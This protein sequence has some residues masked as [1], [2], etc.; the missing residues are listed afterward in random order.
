MVLFWKHVCE[1]V[2]LFKG[3]SD[4][5]KAQNSRTQKHDHQKGKK[6]MSYFLHTNFSF[7]KQPLTHRQPGLAEF[8]NLKNHQFQIIASLFSLGQWRSLY[9]AGRGRYMGRPVRCRRVCA[10]RGPGWIRSCG[11]KCVKA[12]PFKRLPQN[13]L[14]SE[15]LMKSAIKSPN[16]QAVFCLFQSFM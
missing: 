1:L 11:W 4:H 13:T 7:K 15:I 16:L 12:M 5:F 10:F 3:H 14:E 2:S 8:F 9:P 6:L